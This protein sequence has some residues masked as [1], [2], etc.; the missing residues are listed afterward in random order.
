MSAWGLYLLS[1]LSLLAGSGCVAVQLLSL[2]GPLFDRDPGIREFLWPSSLLLLLAFVSHL[3]LSPMFPTEAL[4]LLEKVIYILR[5]PMGFAW[6]VFTHRHYRLCGIPFRFGGL[7]LPLG[8]LTVANLLAALVLMPI[9]AAGVFKG[10]PLASQALHARVQ[11]PVMAITAL[12]AAISAFL[13]PIRHNSLYPS[14]WAGLRMAAFSLAAYPPL[15]IA[16]LVPYRYPFLPEGVSVHQFGFP[17]Y[18]MTMQLLF[19]SQ[20]FLAKPHRGLM[21]AA[22]SLVQEK[23]ETLSLREREVA[24]LLAAGKSY[25]EIAS[26]CSLSLPTVKSHA[27][28]VYRKLGVAGRSAL[29][30]L[31]SVDG[32]SD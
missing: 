27:S 15:V 1:M 10:P 8:L 17:L 22:D 18:Y 20:F 32:L 9:A 4:V 21:A 16:E 5:L 25:K 24:K 11:I 29:P 3:R 31:G 19:C 14:S 7:T 23:L 26:V 13:L 6:L 28:A 30:L 2:R 12:W